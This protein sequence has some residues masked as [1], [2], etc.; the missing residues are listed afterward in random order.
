MLNVTSCNGT[1][2]VLYFG[3]GIKGVSVSVIYDGG[4]YNRLV[5][6]SG[7]WTTEKT[8]D[9]Y[10]ARSGAFGLKF[11]E[12]NGG[13][14]VR[15]SYTA[16]EKIAH[17]ILFRAFSG[18]TKEITEAVV[19]GFSESNGN[20]FNEMQAAPRLS[21]LVRSQ[22]VISSD[23]VAAK[24]S[25]GKVAAIGAATFEKYFTE[26][27]LNSDGEVAVGH[28]LDF[29]SIE[30]GETIESDEIA[31]VPGED[32]GDALERYARVTAGFNPREIKPAP[33][34][35]C[36]WYYYGANISADIIRENM[37]ALK[38]ANVPVN[39]IQIDDGWAKA[40]GDWESNE[41]FGDMKAL[42]DEIR[43][44]GYTP[45]I[46]IAP[47]AADENSEVYRTHPEWF[48]K[49]LD[50]D[51]IFGY[52][53]MDF[54]HPGAAEYLRK[55][56]TTISREWG[57]RYIKIDLVL[58][59][60]S[61]GRHFD[62]SFNAIRNYRR[63]LRIINEAVTPD[64]YLISCTA[65]I[66]ASTGLVDG[67]RTSSDI[68]EDRESVRKISLQ[69]FRRYYYGGRAFNV[70]FDCFL[71]RTAKNEDEQCFRLCTRTDDEIKTHAATVAAS[72]GAIVFSDKIKLL[73]EKQ[74]AL[75][76][77]IIN[78]KAVDPK[79]LDFDDA[80]LISVVDGGEADGVRTIYFFNFGDKPA[81]RLLALPEKSR[82]Y[83]VWKDADLGEADVIRA[84]MPA[85]T[86]EVFLVGDE[87]SVKAKAKVL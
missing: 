57:Y 72:G 70:D 17:A 46:W 81:E 59:A 71:A 78:I 45:G 53:S 54:S 65:P 8:A 27:E 51:G 84:V 28:Q 58:H 67:T 4:H 49:N 85:F 47:F 64:T 3:Y 6:K 55:I 82:I 24:F 79:P 66:G 75:Y 11:R 32:H 33:V 19:N 29:K 14:T 80:D 35:W 2:S 73:D 20:R 76:K 16:D 30:A 15:A 34:G 56:F 39:L 60:I 48:V 18:M 44:A 31:F 26:I 87:K 43:A 7:E 77:T 40:R 42:A 50:D 38:T 10:V 63:A 13:F 5:K 12:I 61:A 22:S 86:S 69:N 68:F 1:L 37:Y 62:R 41:R 83:A 23:S 25:D 21:R 74:I 52:P 36:S 9:G